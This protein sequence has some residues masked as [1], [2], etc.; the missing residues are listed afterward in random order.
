MRKRRVFALAIAV[1]AGAACIALAVLVQR[2]RFAHFDQHAVSHWMPWLEP[3]VHRSVLEHAA[4]LETRST[5][6]GSLVSLSTYPASIAISGAIV[7][8]CAAVL[9]RRHRQRAGIGLVVLWIAANAIALIGKHEVTRPILHQT[10]FGHHGN[11]PG[12]S[13][14]FPSGHALR[15]IV[16]A[17]S[18]AA[19]AKTG[20][21]VWVWALAVPFALVAIAAHTP[22]D[23]V[24]GVL[25]GIALVGLWVAAEN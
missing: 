5:T 22:T 1:A 13:H 20:R 4:G 7:L 25:A 10:S 8:L 6:G 21:V 24:G 15:A 17:L 12:L 9:W 18:L 2:G 3:P 19:V 11:L 16:V 23:V 14:S